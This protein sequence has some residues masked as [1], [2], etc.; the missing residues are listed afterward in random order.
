MSDLASEVKD[1]EER[2]AALVKQ[3]FYLV[4][5]EAENFVIEKTHLDGTLSFKDSSLEGVISAVEALL[6][7]FPGRFGHSISRSDGTHDSIDGLAAQAGRPAA[8]D[9]QTGT[10]PSAPVEKVDLS[11]AASA[12]APAVDSAGNTGAGANVEAPDAAGPGVPE[13][14]AVIDTSGVIA[15]APG[16]VA[17]GQVGTPADAPAAEVPPVPEGAVES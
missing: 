14:A 5:S 7:K 8:E 13:S 6:E 15:D 2:L 17:T 1:F 12:L 3:G 9:G 11:A 4:V 10:S 16:E